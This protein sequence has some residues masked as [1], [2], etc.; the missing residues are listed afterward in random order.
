MKSMKTET[1]SK[2]YLYG[3]IFLSAFFI[4]FVMLPI[5]FVNIPVLKPG[6][7]SPVD[8]RSP[9]SIKV[10]NREATEKAKEKARREVEPIFIYNKDAEKETE[11]TVKELKEI[12]PEEKKLIKKLL[13]SYYKKG[14]LSEVPQGYKQIVV[15]TPKGKKKRKVSEFLTKE[16]LKEQ[17]QKDLSLLLKDK[18]KV[19]I[20]TNQIFSDIKPNFIYS[21][22][23]TEA[24][25]KEAELK[26]KPIYIELRKGEVIVKKGEKVS[27]SEVKKI[28]II[29]KEKGKGK[30]LNKYLSIFLLSLTLFYVMIKLYSI[31]SPSAAVTKNII[32]SFSVV[33]LDIFLIRIFTFFFKLLFENLNIPIHEGLLYIPVFTSTIFASMFITKKV[34]TLHIL[35]ISIIP[36][37][38]LSKPEFFIVPVSIGII[39]SCFDSRR[40][41]NRE[42]IYKSAFTAGV[43]IT[44][45]QL[46]IL[47]Y[48]FSFDFDV[49][50]IIYPL[51]TLFG[52]LITAITVNGLS[53]IFIN[54][55][56]F[57]TDMVFWEL[58]NLNHPLLRKLVLKAPGTY[59]H[60]V[61][62]A[63][64]AE[65]AAETIGANALL[66]KTGGLFHDIGKLK[67]P[68][69][70]IENQTNGINIHDKLSPEKSA[71]ILRAH[72]E[73]GEE[74]GKKYGLPVKIIDIIKQHHGTKLMKYFYHKAKE[75]Y[76][77]EKVDEKKFRYPGPKP[78]FK[79]AGIVMLADTVEAA[80]RSMKDKNINLDEFI[81]KL[82]METV[83]DGQL[84]QSGLSLKDISLIEKVFKKVL[85]GV[86]HNRIEY[87]DDK[88]DKGNN[89]RN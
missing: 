28:E 36:S 59:S 62:V 37:F 65:A 60:S 75:M 44:A 19:E 21:K 3:L 15:I 42:A 6:D 40:Y 51:L 46:I 70:F 11:K 83:E 85:S 57:T 5:S 89:K 14:I 8:I 9:I 45:I 66:A 47:L 86:Y 58:I 87:P 63:T 7:I 10:E 76:G 24:L 30:S 78:Q 33:I 81:H 73:C 16:R 1:I 52:A 13:L 61:M 31:I 38:M 88:S 80:V 2:L 27:P 64:L 77:E 26:V 41:K 55:F 74:L 18:Q 20:I 84:N 12:S 56:K 79:E 23:R 34:A 48:Y 68:Q 69:A 67:N 4:T 17:L 25:K 72:V 50:F 39:F 29:R 22:E 54:I 53:P 43:A 71:T 49:A 35:P 82:I 32:F